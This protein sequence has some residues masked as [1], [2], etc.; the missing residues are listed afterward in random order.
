MILANIRQVS[1]NERYSPLKIYRRRAAPRSNAV[2]IPAATSRTSQTS[3]PP[4]GASLA[5]PV[6]TWSIIRP[7]DGFQS[8]GPSMK[9]G[10][11][12]TASSPAS[13]AL[14]H[15][16]LRLAFR[17]DI[18]ARDEFSG[19]RFFIGRMVVVADAQGVHRGN[20]QQPSPFGGRRGDDIPG[21]ADIDGPL[22][23]QPG[24]TDMDLRGRMDH[25]LDPATGLANRLGL[26]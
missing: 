16:L 8:H 24:P 1:R 9:P 13:H 7:D 23:F 15:D 3:F 10:L 6:A 18:R 5:Q 12:I 17:D 22:L 25:S 19:G 2:R 20:I 11:T 4:G 14:E 21:S 26:R